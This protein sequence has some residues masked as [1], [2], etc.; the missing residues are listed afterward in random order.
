MNI[1][2]LDHDPVIAAQCQHDRHVIKMISETTQL[3]SAWA[4]QY[5]DAPDEDLAN[6]VEVYQEVEWTRLAYQTH[7]CTKWL[8]EG[9]GNVHWLV[10]HLHG[11]VTEYDYRYG[12]ADS[13]PRARQMLKILY[14]W[15]E[16]YVMINNSCPV[17]VMPDEYKPEK[18]EREEVMWA[19]RKYYNA[20]KLKG[21]KYT[22]RAPP[23]WEDRP[24][25]IVIVPPKPVDIYALVIPK[26][27]SVAAPVVVQNKSKIS[28]A[29][30]KI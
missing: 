24:K 30:L 27:P 15:F 11:L 5:K 16:Q 26:K 3:L 14:P 21:N 8:L 18:R 10:R 9:P 17:A 22:K 23:E 12:K 6:F 19:Y 29:S 28:A 13:F 7:P 20:E 25:P 4:D 1:F 2:Y